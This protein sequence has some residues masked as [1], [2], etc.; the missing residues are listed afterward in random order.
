MQRISLLFLTSSLTCMNHPKPSPSRS[1]NTSSRKP[2]GKQAGLVSVLAPLALAGST[3]GLAAT[4]ARALTLFAGP[5]APANWTQSIEGD[6]SINTSGAPGNITL[7]GPSDDSNVAQNV[8]FTIAAPGSGTVS[9]DW[10]Y[11]TIDSVPRHDPF[12]YLLNGS[13]ILLT[14]DNGSAVQSGTA[15]FS[16]LTGDVFGFRQRTTDSLFGGASTTIS[17]FNG[18]TSAPPSSVPG[19]LPLLGAGAAWGWSRRLRQRIASPVITPPRA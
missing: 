9:F 11:S 3:L 12:G 14:S 4:P 15:S 2:C 18:P 7:D 1:A 17:N 10:S 6:G 13:F 8:D 16:V 5:Y 19:P